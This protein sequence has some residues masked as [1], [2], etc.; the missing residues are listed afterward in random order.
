VTVETCRH[1]ELETGNR[2]IEYVPLHSSPAGLRYGRVHEKLPVTD[3][4]S[5]RLIRLP[6]WVGLA[7]E[8]QDHIVRVLKDAVA[9]S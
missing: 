9:G 5:E 8:Q 1:D 3:S 4:A 7:D 2:L 6:L